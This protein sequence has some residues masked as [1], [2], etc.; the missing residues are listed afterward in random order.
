MCGGVQ[1]AGVRKRR[2]NTKSPKQ[3]APRVTGIRSGLGERMLS[4][5]SV[6]PSPNAVHACCEDDGRRELKA[7]GNPERIDFNQPCFH[8]SWGLD[9]HWQWDT[10]IY[11]DPFT[12]DS[13][14]V[15]V[16]LWE[17]LLL[18][19]FICVHTVHVGKQ[20]KNTPLDP[21]TNTPIHIPDEKQ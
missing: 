16:V 4:S 3:S 19:R 7:S 6:K 2:G 5:L 20:W 10:T 1:S 9:I 13:T 17:L 21:T 15:Y 11:C 14:N 18:L 12:A 8:L